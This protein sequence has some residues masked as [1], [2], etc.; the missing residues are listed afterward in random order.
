[1][2]GDHST[3]S[4][5]SICAVD[6]N[7]TK[8]NPTD[9]DTSCD[10]DIA[11]TLPG[12]DLVANTKLNLGEVLLCFLALSWLLVVFS[13]R[14]VVFSYH[15]HHRRL[16]FLLPLFAVI[17]VIAKANPHVLQGASSG[18]VR[19]WRRQRA[20]MRTKE[21]GASSLVHG[22]SGW[23]MGRYCVRDS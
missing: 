14:D 13:L 8:Q 10:V 12:T 2:C 18:C 15:H 5:V 6:A 1:M 19:C 20:C 7:D 22:G 11:T 9:P 3:K 4:G 23:G 16:H 17:S 21:G